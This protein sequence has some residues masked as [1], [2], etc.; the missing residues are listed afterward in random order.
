MTFDSPEL[1]VERGSICRDVQWMREN[2]DV[3]WS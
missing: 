1:L 2:V 3:W